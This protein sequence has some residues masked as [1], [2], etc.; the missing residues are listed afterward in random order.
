MEGAA[1]LRLLLDTHIWVWSLLEPDRLSRTV[2]AALNDLDNE[3][4]LSPLSLY[5]AWVLNER[6]LYALSK[7][8]EQWVREAL[9]A[10]PLSEATLTLEVAHEVKKLAFPHRDPIDRFLVASARVYDLTMV[11]SDRR[12]IES[13]SVPTLS[14]R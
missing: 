7:P 1:R 14:N 5:E 13:R 2:Q 8:F 6:N 4:W 10:S 3:R 11:T 9:A 12:I